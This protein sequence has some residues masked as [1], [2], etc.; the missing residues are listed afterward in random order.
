MTDVSA[1]TFNPQNSS[2]FVVFSPGTIKIVHIESLR[3]L[4]ALNIRC[5]DDDHDD[6]DDNNDNDDD[7][8]D[9]DDDE[10][11]DDDED[12]KNS[13]MKKKD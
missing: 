3:N 6:H 5:D 1:I 9:F 2:E 4:V 7:D 12:N 13:Y 8:D 10:D 11:D